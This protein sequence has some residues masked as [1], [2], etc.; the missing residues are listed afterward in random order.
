M[1]DD[2]FVGLP[3]PSSASAPAGVEQR[4]AVSIKKDS[5]SAPAPAPIPS[6]API[7]KSSLKRGKPPET[8]VE[9]APQK[10]IRFK[11]TTDATEA[12]VLEAMQKIASHI[13][14]P[15]KFSKASK[16]ALQLIQAGSVKAGTSDHFF[17]ILEAA[18]SSPS[19][20]KES[21]L[22]ADYQ[23]LFSAAQDV[24]EH[25]TKQQKDQLVTWTIRAV[26]ANDL[27]TDDSFVV[28]AVGKRC[29]EELRVLNLGGWGY[30]VVWLHSN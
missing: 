30:V 14:N 21:S 5:S 7:L 1:A 29:R 10:R 20:C 3:P 26:V 6:P 22:R 19:A 9:V 27:Y 24:V 12:Q 23:A 17:A 16:L 28:V 15:S 13:K 25:F 8:P 18:M 11:T 4:S 2:L